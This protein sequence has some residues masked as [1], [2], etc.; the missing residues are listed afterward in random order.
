MQEMVSYATV[1]LCCFKFYQVVQRQGLS[2][3][4]SL[5]A[6]QHPSLK[7]VPSAIPHL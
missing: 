3:V 7:E 5:L 6:L 4:G 1:T 2:E